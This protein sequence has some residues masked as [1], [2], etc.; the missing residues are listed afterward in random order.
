M[1]I[2]KN[3]ECDYKVKDYIIAGSDSPNTIRLHNR[4]RDFC[5]VC[6]SNLEYVNELQ[7]KA[8]KYKKSMNL[9]KK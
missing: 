7:L 8:E 3:K 6:F 2:C 9:N 1:Y 5:P 4:G